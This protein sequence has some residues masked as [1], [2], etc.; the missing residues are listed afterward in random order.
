MPMNLSVSISCREKFDFFGHEINN[1]SIWCRLI[2][3]IPSKV[4]NS[5]EDAIERGVQI[6]S[7]VFGEET[8][9]V[10]AVFLKQ[11]VLAAVAAIGGGIR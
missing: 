3:S 4:R 10:A 7:E 11:G 6:F 8:Q 5:P 1:M 9:D 2:S